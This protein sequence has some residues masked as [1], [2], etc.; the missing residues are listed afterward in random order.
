MDHNSANGYIHDIS[1]GQRFFKGIV[2]DKGIEEV[3]YVIIGDKRDFIRNGDG[4]IS[5]VFPCTHLQFALLMHS[6]KGVLHEIDEDVL[7]ERAV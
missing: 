1:L 7:D 6:V 4:C 3:L 5:A 2:Y